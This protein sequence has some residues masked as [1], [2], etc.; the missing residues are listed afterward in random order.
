MTSNYDNT[1]L[2]PLE[3]NDKKTS[4]K[5]DK[6]PGS[7]VSQGLLINKCVSRKLVCRAQSPEGTLSYGGDAS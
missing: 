2:P 1:K 5:G 3:L 7:I 6:L 4:W